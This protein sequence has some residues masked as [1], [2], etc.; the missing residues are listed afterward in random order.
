[1]TSGNFLVDMH[2]AH[3]TKMRKCRE[4]N[5]TGSIPWNEI[6]DGME[7]M[8]DRLARIAYRR[9]MNGNEIKSLSEMLSVARIVKEEGCTCPECDGLGEL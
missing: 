8:M 9:R 7:M 4:C 1:M 6:T 5:G 2:Q 3:D